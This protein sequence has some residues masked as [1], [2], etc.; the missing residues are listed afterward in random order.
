M[1]KSL[2]RHMATTIAEEIKHEIDRTEEEFGPFHS[3]HEGLAVLREE[4]Q[5]LEQEV[6]WGHRESGNTDGVRREAIQVAAMAMRLAM[7]ISPVPY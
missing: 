3:L 2:R 1:N 7:M 5:K 6:F 4:Y